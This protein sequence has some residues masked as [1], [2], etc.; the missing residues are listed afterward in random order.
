MSRSNLGSVDLKIN[1]G[2]TSCIHLS[3]LSVKTTNL[4]FTQKFDIEKMN[5]SQNQINYGHIIKRNK[6]NKF[7]EQ[8]RTTNDYRNRK[9][10]TILVVNLHQND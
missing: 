10:S 7:G 4:V 1:I 5:I 2:K 9:N 3:F 6:E 8:P